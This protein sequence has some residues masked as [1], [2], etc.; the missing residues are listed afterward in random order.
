MNPITLLAATL[1]SA[2]DQRCIDGWVAAANSM[3]QPVEDYFAAFLREQG[4]EFANRYK[5][6]VMPSSEF[7]LRFTAAEIG[8][9]IEA[10]QTDSN[11]AELLAEVRRE[12]SVAADDPRIGPGLQYLIGA[13]LLDESRLPE[14]TAYERPLPRDF[15]AEAEAEASR[16]GRFATGGQG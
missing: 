8:A 2:S 16:A 6:G 15:E 11:V 5:V 13:G 14:I 4:Q 10:A 1:E 7:L 12:A 3:G 9:I